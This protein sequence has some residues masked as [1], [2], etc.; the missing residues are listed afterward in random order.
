M[1][2]R[3]TPARSSRPRRSPGAHRRATTTWAAITWSGRATWCSRRPRCWPADASDTALRALVYLACTQRPDGSFAQNFWIDGTPYWT[4][5][6]LDEV[7]FP[8]MLAWRLWKHGRAGQFRRLSVRRAGRGV[9][10]AL[11]S[12]DAAGAL[13]RER[14]LLAIDARRGDLGAGLRGGHCARAPGDGAG[15]AI[16]RRMPTGSKPISMSGR[17]R[18]K[19]CCYPDV[20]YH[21]MRIRPPA[22][23]EP[24]HNPTLASGHASTSPTASRERSTTSKP[25]R[26][27][28]AGFLELVRY[29]I[30]RA[31]DPLIVD[32]LKV[33]DHVLKIETPYGACW[34]RYN[35]DGY[36]QRKDGGPLRRLGA[37]TRVADPD[38]RA[39]PLRA[40]AGQR[41]QPLHQGDRAVQLRS[42]AC[43]PSR[44]GT[45]P[46]FRPKGMYLGRSAGSAQP[47]VWAHAE[48]LKLLRSAVDGRVFDRISVVEERYGVAA[49]QAHLYQPYRDLRGDSA[50]IDD[51][52]RVYAADRRP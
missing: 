9:P 23:G 38:G 26:S 51:F 37:G 17:R 25:A 18:P 20:K 16:W 1:R 50:G 12:G 39:R 34:R 33:V 21:Y 6:Q 22:E 11:C 14:R 27:S 43:C 24:F 32:S 28:T 40:C 5:I 47:L 52:F 2:T 44:C 4:G 30:R 8:I 10:G 42:A 19:A 31:D 7:A 46:T 41:L 45:M 29:G 13:G 3:P 36:G 49:G 35:H 15:A 48:Y